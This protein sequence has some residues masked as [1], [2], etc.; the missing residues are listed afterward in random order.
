MIKLLIIY[1]EILGNM[2][3]LTF[4]SPLNTIMNGM[5]IPKKNCIVLVRLD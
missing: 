1:K 3:L 5:M 2:P 4:S